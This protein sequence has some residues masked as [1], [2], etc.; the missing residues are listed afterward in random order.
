MHTGEVDIKKTYGTARETWRWGPDFSVFTGAIAD[1]FA[2]NGAR[3]TVVQLSIQ[4]G[5]LEFCK[6]S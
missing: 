3:D 4:L 1:Y 5:Q 6:D 2:V